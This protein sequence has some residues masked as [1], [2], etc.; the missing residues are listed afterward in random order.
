[1]RPRNLEINSDYP[2]EARITLRGP[3]HCCKG[4]SPSEVHAILDLA[5]RRP[6]RADVSI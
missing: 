5:G 4:M 3:E 2:F 6:G 1:M